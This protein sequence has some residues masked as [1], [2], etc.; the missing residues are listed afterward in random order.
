MSI[1]P[2]PKSVDPFKLAEQAVELKGEIALSQLERLVSQLDDKSGVVEVFLSFGKDEEGIR[3]ITGRLSAR[4]TLIC[5]RCLEPL[6]VDLDASLHLGLVFSEEAAK[7]LPKRY[8]PI[9]LET[10]TLQLWELIEEELLLSLPLVPMHDDQGCNSIL[11]AQEQQDQAP[12][13]E[14]PFAVLASLK[15]DSSEN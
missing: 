6:V 13:R 15:K 12:Q 5:Q 10:N 4:L 8:D 3:F 14:N 9:L 7:Q 2:L 11:A 1:S